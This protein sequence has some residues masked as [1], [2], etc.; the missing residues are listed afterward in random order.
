MSH[1]YCLLLLSQGPSL[2]FINQS[3]MMENIFYKTLGPEMLDHAASRCLGTKISIWIY[4]TQDPSPQT[5]GWKQVRE[6][7]MSPLSYICTTRC[8]KWRGCSRWTSGL[9]STNLLPIACQ[10]HVTLETADHVMWQYILASEVICNVICVADS[11]FSVGL[12]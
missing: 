1:V 7:V 11:R 6:E 4:A 12:S 8:Q 3:E 5:P 9:A 10:G 2:F